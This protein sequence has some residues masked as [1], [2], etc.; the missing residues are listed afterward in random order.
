[1]GKQ[2]TDYLLYRW[3]YALGYSL[4]GFIILVLIV[5]A[6]LF[7]PGGLSGDEIQSVVASS[8]ISL[9][10]SSIHPET[11]INF[12]Y[13]LL[14]HASISLFGV[15]NF[16]IK[17]PSILLGLLS[18]GGIFILLRSWFRE[19]IAIL[20]GIIIITTGPFLYVAQSGTPSIVYIFWSVWLLV[21][22]MMTSRR[23]HFTGIW[24]VILFAIAALSIYTPLSIYILIALISA[25]VLHPH[26]RFLVRKLSKV[27]LAIGIV[28]ALALI[29]P[30]VY[31][32]IKQPSVGLTLL[33]VPSSQP[34]IKANVLQLLRQYFDFISPSSSIVITP[35]YGL[36]SVILIALGFVQ[37]A[38]TKY[39]ARSYIISA[40]I[41]LLVP[42]LLVN[43]GYISITFIPVLLLMAM[44]VSLL[45][46]SW[47]SL[48]PRNPYARFAGLLPLTVLIGGLV[49][50]G[51]GRYMYGYTYDP[52]TANYFSH[53]LVLLNKE[54]KT[55]KG[56]ALL[57]TSQSEKPFY[58]VVAQH[59]EGLSV[60]DT[61]QPM[62]ANAAPTIIITHTAHQAAATAPNLYRIIT[63]TTS[64]N[65]DRFYIYK[66]NQK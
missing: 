52:K 51:V 55:I 38:T 66:T 53:D 20:T 19:N 54:I 3:R 2:L 28:V 14:Q 49:L 32:I 50:S 61:T 64:N 12:P 42:A 30:L 37:L 44:G 13:H 6:G 4:I 65:A 58:S 31:A 24:K 15:S 16:S 17:L 27:K 18:V 48:F 22:A 62:A 25:V 1:M 39:T 11:I 35:I 59:H 57:V 46:G 60:I 23:A 41:I 26:L 34:D 45:L 9:S 29:S 10:P 8:A 7:I 43:P 63:N 5:V 40:W 47:Y 21:S 33:G 36:G 56:P